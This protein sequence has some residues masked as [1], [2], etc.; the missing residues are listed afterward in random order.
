[1][2]NER[3]CFP[4]LRIRNSR[5]FLAIRIILRYIRRA[6]ERVLII[7]LEKNFC[8][9]FRSPGSPGYV[10]EKYSISAAGAM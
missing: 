4:F 10:P 8:L 1:M 6:G 5:F 2:P 3:N 9:A 7:S